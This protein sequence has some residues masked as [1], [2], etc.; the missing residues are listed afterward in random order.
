MLL[1]AQTGVGVTVV[2]TQ[3]TANNQQFAAQAGAVGYQRLYVPMG[4]AHNAASVHQKNLSNQRQHRMTVTMT[5]TILKTQGQAVPGLHKQLYYQLVS[6]K[7]NM[8][9]RCNLNTAKE[10]RKRQESERGYSE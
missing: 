4:A 10:R 9:T 6:A 3:H 5:A 7:G 2:A 1:E 8:P